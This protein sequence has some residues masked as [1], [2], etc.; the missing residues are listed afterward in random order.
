MKMKM[1]LQFASVVKHGNL[2]MCQDYGLRYW[3]CQALQKSFIV[4]KFYLSPK[5][6]SWLPLTP[7]L[8]TVL[9]F[10][11]LKRAYLKCLN[12]SKRVPVLVEEQKQ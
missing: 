8:Y 7:E 3:E 6:K 9:F 5:D 1:N 4:A 12:K 2:R 10:F 11:Q